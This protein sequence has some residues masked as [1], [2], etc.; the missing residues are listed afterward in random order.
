MYRICVTRM[1]CWH[2]D[3]LQ[4]VLVTMQLSELSRCLFVLIDGEPADSG[5]VRTAREYADTNACSITL[6]RVL[7][8]VNR[9][10][11]G[12]RGVVIPPG[13]TRLAMKAYSKRHLEKL[14]AQ[15]LRD[16]ARP[17]RTLVRFGDVINELARASDAGQ[18]H[19]VMARSRA[20]SFLPWRGRDRRLQR[21]LRMPVILLD[22]ADRL[23]GSPADEA[24]AAPLNISDK[25]RAIH[26][27][28]AFADLSRKEL[29]EVAR[30]LDEAQV[31][32]GTTVVHE[33]TSNHA[34]WIV[35]D[36]ELDLTV[37]GKV[38]ERVTSP[39]L[40]GAPSMLDGQP[41]WATVTAVT[42]VRAL[43][44]GRSQFRAICADNRIALR[45]WAATGT[46]LRH[47]LLH[48]MSEA[49]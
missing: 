17:T 37:R 15:F 28:P 20:G 48:S 35:L 31:D 38:L 21:K 7:P 42:R 46:R 14:K 12:D 24:I 11:R 40:V 23:I 49:G 39:G 16:R 27:L 8:E 32:A 44:A 9:A 41:A 43:V 34:F 36:G 10:F 25:V 45:L 13:Q 6:L 4:P 22:A 3:V 5:L 2:D 1:F 29:V 33:G 26:R 18:P 30:N 47:H 19:A